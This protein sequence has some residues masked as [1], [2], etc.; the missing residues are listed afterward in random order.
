MYATDRRQTRASS[1][2]AP[3]FEGRGIIINLNH[4]TGSQFNE[5]DELTEI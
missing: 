4:R 1:L 2:N 3:Y 5:K